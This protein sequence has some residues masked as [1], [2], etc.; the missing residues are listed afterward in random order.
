MKPHDMMKVKGTFCRPDV[1]QWMKWNCF[2]LLRGFKMQIKTA[3]ITSA[4]F[5]SS[6][7][8]S[9][10]WSTPTDLSWLLLM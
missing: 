7:S 4:P 1:L 6:L 3:L 9:L 10:L 2:N 5:H 8:L